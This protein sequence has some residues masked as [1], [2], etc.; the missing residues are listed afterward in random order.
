[1]ETSFNVLNV[2]FFR[3]KHRLNQFITILCYSRNI[4]DV[5]WPS[6]E[7]HDKAKKKNLPL[8]LNYQNKYETIHTYRTQVY[9][10]YIRLNT[11]NN[12]ESIF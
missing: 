6:S 12:R 2:F 8:D 5:L 7:I 4:T 10:C 3:E 9:D 11:R 1:M